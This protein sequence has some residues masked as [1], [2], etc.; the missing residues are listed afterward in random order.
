M[1][2]IRI[3]Q[4]NAFDLVVPLILAG[5]EHID[6]A[7][8]T[9]L[10]VIVRQSHGAQVAATI[11]ASEDTAVISFADLLALGSYDCLITGKYDTRNIALP[12]NNVFAIC[13]YSND[14]TFA[15]RV[16]GNTITT[17]P[18][19]L[20]GWW[21]TDAELNALKAAYRTAIADYNAATADLEDKARQIEGVAQ[22]GTDTTATN[23]RLLYEI[24]HLVVPPPTGV[25]QQDTLTQGIADIRGD[26]AGID[27]DTT[28][29]AKQGTNA[30]ATLTDTQAA[31]KDGNDTAVGVA[32]EIRSEV[33]TG[34]DTAAESGTLFAVVKWVKDKVKSIFNLIGSPASGQE[35][36]LF[37]ALANINIDTTTIAKQG[38]N[39]NANI[40]DIQSLIGYT[41]QEIDGV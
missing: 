38:S 2:T 7:L 23:T 9:D 1:K 30:S 11:T 10:E 41:I 37:G 34:S 13:E 26:I 29:L 15:E 21:A 32:K 14:A 19:P 36:T 39:A 22:Q 20:V 28:T 31:V 40:S 4:G 27:I 6:A 12:L 33:G 5:G 16:V 18:Q 3:P 25:A 35:P 8:L 17:E 24:T